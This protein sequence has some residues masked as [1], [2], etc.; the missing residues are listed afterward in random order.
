MLA[1]RSHIGLG[2]T[3]SQLEKVRK[4]LKEDLKEQWLTGLR[5]SFT[6]GQRITYAVQA[7]LLDAFAKNTLQLDVDKMRREL[8]EAVDELS[9]YTHI[10]PAVFGVTGPPLDALVTESFRIRL[11][12]T[13]YRHTSTI[14]WPYIRDTGSGVVLSRRIET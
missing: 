4:L 2:R 8:L 1:V 13:P 7:G 5:L 11:H 3:A 12:W 10:T 14:P 9:K 6:R